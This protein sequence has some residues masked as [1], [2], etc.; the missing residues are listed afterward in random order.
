MATRLAAAVVLV[1]FI[2]LAIATAVGLKTGE[3]L[4]KDIYQDRLSALQSTGAADVAAQLNSTT[5]MATSLAASPQAVIALDEFDDALRTLDA[6]PPD[7]LEIDVDRMIEDYEERYIGPL[8]D[9]GREIALPDLVDDTGSALYLQFNYAVDL[10]AI[11][12]PVLVDDA[13]DGSR[14]SEVHAVV[15]PVYRDVVDD[16]GLLDLYLVE[17]TDRRVVYS[18]GKG[19]DLG[20]SLKVGPFSG[21]VLA[22]TVDRVMD[23]PDAG[24]AVSDL[25][26]YAGVPEVPVGVVASPVM[27][28]DRLVGVLALM[29]DGMVFTDILTANGKWEDAGYPDTSDTYLVGDDGTTRSDPRLFVEA[30]QVYL[31]ASQESGILS[32]SERAAIEAAGTTVLI[33]PV[34]D[35]TFTAG[36]DG[37][38]DVVRRSSLTGAD[39]ASVIAPIPNDDVTWFVVAEI[40]IVAAESEVSDFRDTLIVGAAI[41]IVIIAFFAVAWANRIMK[42]VRMISERLGSTGQD[43]DPVDIAERAPVELQN[44]ATSFESMSDTLDQQQIRLAIVREER[45]QTMREMLPTAVAERIAAGD[46]QNVDEVPEATVVVLVVLGLS[47]LVRSD[48]DGSDRETV[49]RLHAE[50]DD[51]ALQN[52]LDRVKVVGDAYFAAC[53]HDRP[54]IDH[55]PRAIAF[56]ADAHDVIRELSLDSPADLDVAVGIDTGPVIVGMTGGTRLVYDVWGETVTV[57]H[58]LARRAGRGQILISEQSKDLLPASIETDL[59]SGSGGHDAIWSVDSSSVGGPT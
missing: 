30:P 31:D 36:E 48:G 18:V 37:D 23:N 21:S 34:I 53:G 52:G 40:S 38:D 32:E 58:H 29:Y 5:R 1:S 6:L 20:T 2:S 9:H 3:E 41:F 39:V 43:H 8:N 49:D 17:P 51:L 24:T 15:H 14:W 45:L 10:S 11:T 50:L 16:L 4:G 59:V 56:A 25:S 55:A 13:D 12:D 35:A 19:P 28:G 7:D 54:Y 57:A 27:D 42:P 22:N 46:L 44:L 47:D 33:Q 26:F